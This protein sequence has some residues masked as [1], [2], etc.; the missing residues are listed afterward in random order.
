MAP[1]VCTVPCGEAKGLLFV[2]Q[3]ELGCSAGDGPGTRVP[4][5]PDGVS[6]AGSSALRL[7]S[8]RR[9]GDGSGITLPTSLSSLSFLLS[10][11]D[12]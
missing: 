4:G 1:G 5:E 6:Q 10:P 3:S 11:G 9:G 12:P 8:C 2:P 7:S